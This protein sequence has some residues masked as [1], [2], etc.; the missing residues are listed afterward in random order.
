MKN[1]KNTVAAITLM[2]VISFGT[3]FANAGIIVAGFNEKTT[4]ERTCTQTT[5]KTPKLDWGI[6]V[7]GLRGIIVAGF[8]GI[9]V[10][11]AT[12]TPTV[13][14]GIIVAG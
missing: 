4:T 11:G 9:I 3:T 10:A 5:T 2:A 7:A 8:T 13:D 14:C 6:I 12:D 1:L